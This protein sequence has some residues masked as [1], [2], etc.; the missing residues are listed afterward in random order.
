M[1]ID[2]A[3]TREGSRR[4]TGKTRGSKHEPPLYLE[5]RGGRCVVYSFYK[6][7]VLCCLGLRE[8]I[9]KSSMREESMLDRIGT[10][11][12]VLHGA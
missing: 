3:S 5:E 2:W 12:C 1:T 10:F 7:F 8:C 9:K 4:R 11:R 6:F